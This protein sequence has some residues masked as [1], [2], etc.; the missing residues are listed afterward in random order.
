MQVLHVSSEE[1][2]LCIPLEEPREQGREEGL[3]VAA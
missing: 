1:Y 3:A 2:S